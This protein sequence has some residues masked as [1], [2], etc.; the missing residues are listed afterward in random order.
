MGSAMWAVWGYVLR[1]DS[2]EE[3]LVYRLRGR[4]RG[5]AEMTSTKITLHCTRFDTT[6]DDN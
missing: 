3:V 2:G 6:A 5:I 4:E 1:W